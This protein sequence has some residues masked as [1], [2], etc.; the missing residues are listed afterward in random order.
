MT[1]S[2]LGTVESPILVD[3]DVVMHDVRSD[4]RIVRNCF[5]CLSHRLVWQTPSSKSARPAV[6]QES[7]AT[8]GSISKISF[9]VQP[10]AVPTAPRKTLLG[11]PHPFQADFSLLIL[12]TVEPFPR[13]VSATSCQV[14][15]TKQRAPDRTAGWRTRHEPAV[16]SSLDFAAHALGGHLLA[17]GNEDG[18]ITLLD[19]RSPANTSPEGAWKRFVFVSLLPSAGSISWSAHANVIFDL[20]WLENDDKLASAGGDASARIWDSE[21]RVSE[22]LLAHPI[23]FGLRSDVWRISV[24]T[25][26]A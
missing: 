22:K 7:R 3:D 8:T 24:V 6:H 2:A 20:L 11:L 14:F 25:V 4:S 13:N 12:P 9:T 17:S 5:A 23:F 15:E 26:S 16:T 21:T 19:T 1:S 10:W 18:I